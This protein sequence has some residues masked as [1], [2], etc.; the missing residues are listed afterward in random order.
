MIEKVEKLKNGRY[1]IYYKSGRTVIYNKLP[2]SALKAGFKDDITKE[3]ES[4][5][6][7][8]N[9]G[10]SE[11]QTEYKSKNSKGRTL[12]II[13][14][15]DN[16]D[17]MNF[18]EWLKNHE[19][20]IYILHTSEKIQGLPYSDFVDV[21][22]EENHDYKPHIHIMLSFPNPISVNGFVK[23]SAGAVKHAE[24]VS[25]KRS[26]CRYMIHDTYASLKAHKTEYS[27]NDIKFTDKDFFLSCVLDSRNDS[28]VSAF[29][30]ITNLIDNE[31]IV[32]LPEL[33]QAVKVLKRLDLLTFCMK[34]GYILS[35]YIRDNRLIYFGK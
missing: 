33:V 8:K 3:S 15:P 34:R 21:L 28:E 9:L 2:K 25:D 19:K 30:E 22:P 4:K 5:E 14:Y 16:Q 17:Q 18:F 11:K 1:K 35:A 12:A 23:S 32:S 13:L 29:A 27:Y 7:I 10:K 26:Y 31:C 24:I 20:L 6:A